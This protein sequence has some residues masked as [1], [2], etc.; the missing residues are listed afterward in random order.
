MSSKAV[1]GVVLAVLFITSACISA[2]FNLQLLLLT[3]PLFVI[4]SLYLLIR[5]KKYIV[6]DAGGA[7]LIGTVFGFMLEYF[8]VLNHIWNYNRHWFVFKGS[9]PGGVPVE[10]MIWAFFWAFFII[11]FYEHFFDQYSRGKFSCLFLPMSGFALLGIINLL[12]A[13]LTE[14]FFTVRYAYAWW[15]LFS[16]LPVAAVLWMYPRAFPK[17]LGT[18]VIL[19]V[20]GMLFEWVAIKTGYWSFGGEYLGMLGSGILAVPFE[21]IVFWVLLGPLVVLS[22]FLLFVRAND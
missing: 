11:L 7:F 17:L 16:L 19:A 22:N 5:G 8:S 10:I 13:P 20:A 3:V 21:E 4:P 2:F 12:F 18:G 15:G 6:R 14:Q 9:L 1:D